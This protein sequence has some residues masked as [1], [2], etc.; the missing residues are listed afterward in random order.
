LLFDLPGKFGP[1]L[2]RYKTLFTLI[3]IRGVARVLHRL[4]GLRRVML[5]SESEINHL[6]KPPQRPAISRSQ[7]EPPQWSYGSQDERSMIALDL[8]TLFANAVH[9]SASSKNVCFSFGSMDSAAISLHRRAL[10]RYFSGSLGITLFLRPAHTT[11]RRNTGLQ[12]PA[13]I[14][15][16]VNLAVEAKRTALAP[17]KP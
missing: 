16:S 15:R 13:R 10:A 17:G 2:G 5:K 11:Q 14:M 4:G 9:A 8:S 1:P 7:G 6:T 3:L 12:F